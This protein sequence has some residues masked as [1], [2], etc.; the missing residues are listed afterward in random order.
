[1][2]ELILPRD[3]TA[4]RLREL[5][6]YD[7]ETG[8]FT[9]KNPRAWGF[10]MPVG[11]ISDKSYRIIKLSGT[12]YSASRLAWLYIAG[13]WPER[14]LEHI[15]GNNL[16]DRI[17]NLRYA[18]NIRNVSR[19]VS[20]IPAQELREWFNYNPESGEILWSRAPSSRIHKG[21]QAGNIDITTGYHHVYFRGKSI[22]GHRLAWLLYYGEWPKL[23]LDHINQVKSD[24]RIKNL[25]QVTNS[26]NLQNRGVTKNKATPKGVSLNMQGSLLYAIAGLRV[27]SR[28]FSKAF[29]VVGGDIESAVALAERAYKAWQAEYHT[30][31]P[32]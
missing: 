31:A 7:P 24:N 29:R 1:M 22:K 18:F 3:L 21:A 14:R 2:A 10:G 20:E 27:G 5:L 23:Y 25:R 16:N 11:C 9:S 15:D 4:E 26:E 12:S 19:K 28:R 8:I 13:E 32:K 6:H 30:H 17:G